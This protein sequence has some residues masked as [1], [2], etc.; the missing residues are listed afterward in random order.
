MYYISLCVC[1]M[2]TF[3]KHEM[4]CNWIF[5]RVF[6]F[7]LF[8]ITKCVCP[9]S[10]DRHI[11]IHLFIYLSF[12]MFTK[13]CMSIDM[14]TMWLASENQLK[15]CVCVL[16]QLCYKP[17][18]FRNASRNIFNMKM[19]VWG[20]SNR[21]NWKPWNKE[22]AHINLHTQTYRGSFEAIRFHGTLLTR[23]LVMERAANNTWFLSRKFF[24]FLEKQ[25]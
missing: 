2:S 11:I 16:C 15:C 21:G 12:R 1:S 17:I 22:S 6:C 14:Q 18:L 25:P 4:I 5:D 3:D 9:C 8:R 7:I 23:F 10:S 20:R 24:T 19:C 13:I